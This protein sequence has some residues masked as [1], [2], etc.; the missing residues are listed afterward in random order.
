MKFN[1]KKTVA[2]IVIVIAPI[3]LMGAKCDKQSSGN[4]TAATKCNHEGL[5][6][7]W[8]FSKPKPGTYFTCGKAKC[9]VEFKAPGKKSTFVTKAYFPDKPTWI[10]IPVGFKEFKQSGCSAWYKKTT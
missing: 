4:S 8:A 1:F 9:A 7:V 10:T 5:K 6:K 3:F 2:V